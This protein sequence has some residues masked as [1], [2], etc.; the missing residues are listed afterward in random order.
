MTIH[1]DPDTDTDPATRPLQRLHDDE[2]GAQAM[3]YAALA[4][5]GATLV[6]LIVWLLNSEPI[7]NRLVGFL[8]GIIGSV[9]DS[10]GNLL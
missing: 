2:T 4:G 1:T 3:E 9:G 10:L 5:G 8:E 6:S 7:R